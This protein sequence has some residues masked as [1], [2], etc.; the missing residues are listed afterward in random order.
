MAPRDPIKTARNELI[1][2]MKEDLRTM[3][4]G[5]L[6]E[7]GFAS[8]ASLNAMIG[9]KADE[10]IDLHHE[11][12]LSPDQYVT[13]YMKGFK[14]AMSPPGDPFPNAHRRNY[15]RL[16]SSKAAQEYFINLSIKLSSLTFICCKSFLPNPRSRECRRPYSRALG[17]PDFPR[18]KFGPAP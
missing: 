4:P 13:C 10:F 11:V 16:K 8:Q 9:G 7:T 15:E 18:D 12:V 2:K 6:K 17:R 3:L 1:A 14:A 5:V